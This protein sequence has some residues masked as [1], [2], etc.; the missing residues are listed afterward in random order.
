M[1]VPGVVEP[2]GDSGGDPAVSTEMVRT[3]LELVLFLLLFTMVMLRV[4][5]IGASEG[6]T[7]GADREAGKESHLRSLP[8]PDSGAGPASVSSQSLWRKPMISFCL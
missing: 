5:F 6:D 2:S 3:N 8:R 4:I 7:T 1:G